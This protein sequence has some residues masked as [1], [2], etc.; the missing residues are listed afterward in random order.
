L[1]GLK[2]THSGWKECMCVCV[3]VK[4]RK[5]KN[6]KDVRVKKVGVRTSPGGGAYHQTPKHMR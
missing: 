6:I 1:V 2:E 3:Y 4:E 5:K